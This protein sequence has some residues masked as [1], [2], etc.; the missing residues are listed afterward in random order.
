[1]RWYVVL[2]LLIILELVIFLLGKIVKCLLCKCKE[3]LKKLSVFIL[4]F[5]LEILMVFFFLKGC[6]IIR[7]ILLVMFER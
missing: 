7:I 1:M 6:K 5:R 3:V 4:S 2:L